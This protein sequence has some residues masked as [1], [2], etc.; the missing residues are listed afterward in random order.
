MSDRLL[1]CVLLTA[2][3]SIAGMAAGLL[4]RK[5]KEYFEELNNLLVRFSSNLV[6]AM[7]TVPT[8]LGNYKSKSALL[9]RQIAAVVGNIRGED[10]KLPSGFLS[11]A[12]Y[13]FVSDLLSSLGTYNA[14]GERGAAEAGRLRLGDF[15]TAAQTRYDGLGKSSAKL[16]FLFG[17]L[18]AILCL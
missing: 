1:L 10:N 8:V 9:G 18:L 13:A 11:R 17:L 12:E 14:V 5:R 3:G 15:K 7:E 6:Y 16:G 2:G 4:L